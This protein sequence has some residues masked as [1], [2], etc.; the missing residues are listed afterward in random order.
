[1]IWYISVARESRGLASSP[2]GARSVQLA[3]DAELRRLF[4]A[5]VSRRGLLGVR[6]I[7]RATGIP[8]STV[9]RAL[10]TK[11]K[12]TLQPQTRQ[13]IREFLAPESAQ[14]V[15]RETPSEL[16]LRVIA[17]VIQLAATDPARLYEMA[18]MLM[19]V[20]VRPYWGP[21]PGESKGKAEG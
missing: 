17:G 12:Q 2:A 19:S 16:A 18:D 13:L 3:A 6:E 7:S 5:E 15:S 14:N 20:Q 1:M 8:V 11:S 9:A 21:I 4:Q 10:D